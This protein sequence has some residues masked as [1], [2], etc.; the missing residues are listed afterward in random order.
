M[1]HTDGF[2]CGQGNWHEMHRKW[3]F[4]PMDWLQAS[5]GSRALLVSACT[6]RQSERHKGDGL[7]LSRKKGMLQLER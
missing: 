1:G 4:S 6:W 3:I 7:G 5:E 2:D